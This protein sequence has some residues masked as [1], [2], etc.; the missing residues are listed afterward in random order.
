MENFDIGS[1][2]RLLRP[3]RQSGRAF[4]IFVSILLTI[5]LWGVFAWSTQLRRGLSVTGCQLAHQTRNTQKSD[6]S[7]AHRSNENKLSYR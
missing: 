2:T 4:R 3:I 6:R 7:C 1:D 5:A